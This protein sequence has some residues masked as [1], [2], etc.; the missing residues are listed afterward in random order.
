MKPKTLLQ[1]NWFKIIF[2]II[3]VCF[4]VT[5]IIFTRKYKY[6]PIEI[7]QEPIKI[8]SLESPATPIAQNIDLPTLIKN[9]YPSVVRITCYMR[10]TDGTLYEQ[11]GTG[12]LKKEKGSLYAF[13]NKHVISDDEGLLPELCTIKLANNNDP[14]VVKNDMSGEFQHEI[15]IASSTLDFGYLK[16]KQPNQDFIK[17]AANNNIFCS[18]K[19]LIGSSLI[20]IG[21]P[22]VGA[23]SDITVTRGIISGYDGDYYITDAKIGHGNS[24][25]VAIS[26]SENTD[27]ACLLGIPSYTKI[28]EATNLGRILTIQKVKEYIDG[29]KN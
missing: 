28:G 26:V 1:E 24:G 8:I 9:W 11:G 29:L 18:A 5:F 13:T 21:Y 6:S 2:L 10:D 14:Y 17:A 16:I 19:S 23:E 4:L 7:S 22:D 25:G 20:T 15:Q 12:F 27:K 3:C